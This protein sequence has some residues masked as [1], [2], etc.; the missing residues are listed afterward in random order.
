MEPH[1]AFVSTYPPRRCGIATFTRD[2]ATAMGDGE[3]VAIHRPGDPVLYPVEVTSVVMEGAR[4]DYRRA[5][6]QVE[7]GGAAAVSLQHEYGLFGGPDGDCILAFLERVS[8]PV[9]TTLHTVLREPSRGQERVLRSILERSAAVVVMSGA[10]ASLL[11]DRYRVAAPLVRMIPHGVPDLRFVDPADRKPDFGLQGRSVILSFG[12]V[13]PGKGYEHVIDALARVRPEH[14]DVL[15]VI[16]G[17]THPNLV[18]TEGETYR[19]RLGDQVASL[20][21]EQHVRLVDRFVGHEELGR[22][23]QAADIFVTPY[24][25]LDQVVS[26]TLSY[27]LAAG[28]PVV[29]TPFAYAAELLSG[30]LGVLVE[31]GSADA[32]ADGLGRLLADAGQRRELGRRAHRFSRDMVWPRVG[33]A[34]RDLFRSVARQG[35]AAGHAALHVAHG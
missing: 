24:P 28:R 7:H 10:A 17:S 22:W 16:L 13:G 35:V 19:R 31:Q 1:V 4:G 20:G 29:S 27:A 23:L 12:L 26:G 30:G 8:V 15:Y 25:N 32:L 18:R 21:L 11:A 2:L 3:V 5:A 9:V 33:R 6:A 34:Y 14:P